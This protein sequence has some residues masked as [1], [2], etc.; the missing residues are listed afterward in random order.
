MRSML[1]RM[2][3]RFRGCMQV[4][5]TL[6]RSADI[7][8][9]RLQLAVFIDG[10]FWHGCP[11]HYN[12]PRA[13]AGYWARSSAM[14]PETA[15]PTNGSVRPVG[16]F[17]DSGSTSSRRSQR[18]PSPPSS[19]SSVPSIA[20]KPRWQV[21]P[22]PWAAAGCGRRGQGHPR[23]GGCCWPS[24]ASWS[25]RDVGTRLGCQIL[26]PHSVDGATPQHRLT[27][28]CRSS[29]HPRPPVRY[30]LTGRPS[31]AT[32]RSMAG[33]SSATG[34]A[35]SNRPVRGTV[36]SW[37]RAKA[38]ACSARSS[39]R[40]ADWPVAWAR[41]QP[42]ARRSAMRRCSRSAPEAGPNGPW[43]VRSKTPGW[44][45]AAC[46]AALE[47]RYAAAGSSPRWSAPRSGGSDHATGP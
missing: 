11:E 28:R 26:T 23:D 27:L 13:K 3:Y 4:V 21:R 44:S 18:V 33:A 32:R 12:P 5:P 40:S 15:T 8:A 7:V 1:H 46:T 31:R 17:C 41:S 35:G 16:T 39:G 9:P 29:H 19:T 22:V 25:C 38:S 36:R 45:N 14:S 20:G 24:V 47:S 6:R 37:T 34:W 43:Y 30:P 2:G 42:W 10:C